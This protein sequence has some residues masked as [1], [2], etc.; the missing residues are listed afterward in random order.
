MGGELEEQERLK[1][2]E[3]RE[4]HEAILACN[5]DDDGSDCCGP[6]GAVE[7]QPQPGGHPVL[8]PGEPN[9]I[10]QRG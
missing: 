3:R 1:N 9:G 6:L 5:T 7:I 10:F 8:V 4:D 2:V